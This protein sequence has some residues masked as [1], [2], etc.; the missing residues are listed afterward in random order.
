MKF[1]ISIILR[2]Y[3]PVYVFNTKYVS[4]R[5]TLDV[6]KYKTKQTLII[7]FFYYMAYVHRNLQT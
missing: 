5:K 4:C 2:S 1:K 3:N 7:N 6:Y